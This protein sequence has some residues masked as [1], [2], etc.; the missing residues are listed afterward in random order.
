V[1]I[2]TKKILTEKEILTLFSGISQLKPVNEEL[3]GLLNK[4]FEENPV[5][6][7]VGDIFI[8]VA[9]YFK[10]YKV[11]CK[12]QPYA[13]IEYQR[14]K[15]EGKNKKLKLFEEECFRKPECRLMDLQSFLLKPVQRICKYPLL[16]RVCFPSSSSSF[17][18]LFV[19]AQDSFLSIQEILKFTEEGHKDREKLEKAFANIQA[20]VQVVNEATK[21]EA[22]MRRI[23]DLQRT[24]EVA[25]FD[26][27]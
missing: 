4:R 17:S 22:N 21:E 23:L 16:I 25:G 8:A 27:S 26:D 13:M 18:N 7:E 6:E 3:L 1:P 11:Y 20:I 12:N 5:V 24:V 9:E 2:Q 10:M 15:A 19:G 14:I